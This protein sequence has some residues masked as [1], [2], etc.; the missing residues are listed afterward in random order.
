MKVE[1]EGQTFTLAETVDAQE[2]GRRVQR[3]KL[4][5]ITG[6]ATMRQRRWDSGSGVRGGGFCSIRGNGGGTCNGCDSGRDDS[7]S[8]GGAS[9]GSSSEGSNGAGTQRRWR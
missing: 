2:A 5:C 4:V 1:S 7:G 3:G 6:V 9:G 8:K